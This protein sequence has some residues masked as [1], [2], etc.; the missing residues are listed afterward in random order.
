MQQPKTKHDR[1][2][3]EQSV[4]RLASA[5][6]EMLGM[7]VAQEGNVGANRLGQPEA[8]LEHAERAVASE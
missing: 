1:S 7:G 6:R 4:D 5:M 2:A 3:Y 8:N